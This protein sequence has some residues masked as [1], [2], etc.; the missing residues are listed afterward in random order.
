M[1]VAEVQFYD[2]VKWLHISAVVVGL[3]VTFAYGV[4]MATAARSAPRAM[5]GVMDAISTAGKTIVTP[6]VIVILLT[7]IYLTA[8]RW[9]FGDFF[10]GWGMAAVIIL[11]A[12]GIAFFT[13]TEQK[14]RAAAERDLERGEGDRVEF[15]PEFN[16]LSASLAR[17]GM[18]TGI[19]IILT[20]YVMTAK[21]FQ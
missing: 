12:L 10:V 7:G 21:P 8:D 20:V 14:A 17:V 16:R 2:V 1:P 15:S 11:F 19:L 5:P 3:G 9:E 6:G 4:F 13:P 18:G